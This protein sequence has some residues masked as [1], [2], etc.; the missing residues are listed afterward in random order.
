MAVLGLLVQRP[1]SSSSLAEGLG[2]GQI[3]GALKR[4]I[5][6][7]MSRGAIEYTIPD[8]PNSRLQRYRLTAKGRAL[9]AKGGSGQVRERAAKYGRRRR[10]SAAK[11][12]SAPKATGKQPKKARRS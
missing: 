4:S 9:L 11:S 6:R 7:L 5:D 1:M 12:R 8:K 3:S 2:H 10:S